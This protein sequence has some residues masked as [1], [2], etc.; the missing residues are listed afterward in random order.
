MQRSETLAAKKSTLAHLLPRRRTKL[1][2]AMVIAVLLSLLA[3]CGGS[4]DPAASDTAAHNSADV[5]FATDMIPHHAQAIEMADLALK[6]ARS[7]EVVTLAE[8]IKAAQG[9]EIDKMSGWLQNWNEPVPDTM[10]MA[11]MT[12]DR[13]GMMSQA[14]M[15]KLS[16]PSGRAF[17]T[18][19]LTMMVEHHQGAIE[20]A[21]DGTG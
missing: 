2:T 7:T 3:A 16:Q 20:M 13:A 11:G 8:Q 1:L 21:K 12:H 14:D 6:Q 19:W 10:S 4:T 15:D 9:P 17:D 5:T 18:M